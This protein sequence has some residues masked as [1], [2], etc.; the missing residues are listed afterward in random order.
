MKVKNLLKEERSYGGINFAP[1]GVVEVTGRQWAR[2]EGF[3][4]F[5]L[6]EPEKVEKKVRK[7]RK[8]KK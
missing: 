5:E 7:A 8:S 4:D 2:L 6:V 3:G 1:K